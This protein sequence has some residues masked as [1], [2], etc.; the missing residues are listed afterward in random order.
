MFAVQHAYIAVGNKTQILNQRS[1][2]TDGWEPA[3]VWMVQHLAEVV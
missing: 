2:R 1:L 3:T